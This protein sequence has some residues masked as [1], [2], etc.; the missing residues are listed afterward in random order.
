MTSD[1]GYTLVELLVALSLLLLALGMF[2]SALVVVQRTS[3]RQ[4]ERG[5]TTNQI[6]Q[7]LVLMDAQMRSGYATQLTDDARR[8]VLYT[9][10]S[11]SRTCAGWLVT[12]LNP[13]QPSDPQELWATTWAAG[14]PPPTW[15]TGWSLMASGIRNAAVDPGVP[16]FSMKY[17]PSVSSPNAVGVSLGVLF[18][19]DTR[20]S[21]TVA[22]MRAGDASRIATTFSTRNVRR[23]DT[24]IPALGVPPR[25]AC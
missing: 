23:Y 19:V 9:E 5:V 1:R 6:R 16:P 18:W 13:S 3:A 7:A 15:P 21:A 4:L 20:Q 12:P 11:G 17:Y 22:E 25:A 2:G 10:A 24:V 14:G 8:V